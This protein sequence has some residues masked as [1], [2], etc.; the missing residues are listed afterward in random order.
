MSVSMLPA[1]AEVVQVGSGSYT[2]TYPGVDEKNRN[3]VPR[4]LPQVSGRAA[5]RPIPTNDWWSNV[6][7]ENQSGNL[8]AYP[9]AMRTKTDG[10]ALAYIPKGPMIDFD[11]VRV[12]V[13][14]ISSDKT[15]VSDFSDWTVTMRWGNDSEYFEGTA[16][17]AM[18]F[19]YFTK[20]S[21]Q[22][23]KIA[24]Y[25][26]FGTVTVKDEML[27]V[28]KGF[29]GASFAVYAP[30]GSEWTLTGGKTYESSLGGKDYWSVAML[31]LD[32]PDAVEAASQLKKY[33]YVFPKDTRALW[34]FDEKTSVVRTDYVVT[35]DVKEGAESQVLMGLL[36]HHWAHLSAD[37]AQPDGASYTTIRGEMKTLGGNKF[38]T[39]N[40]FH[41]ILP[42][43][44]YVEEGKNGFSTEELDALIASVTGDHGLVDWTD[45]YNDGQL[46]NRLI[47]TARVAK[48]AGNEAEFK[49]AFDLIKDRVENWLTYSDGE[50]AFLFYYHKDW[51]ALLGYPA[52][53]GQDEY[54]NDHHFHW[55]YFIHAAAFLEQ[56]EPGW[57]ERWGEMVDLLVR[58]AATT[59]RDD[60]MFPYIRN[61]SPFAGHCWANGV[62]V[63]PQGNDQESSSESMQFHSSLIHWGA[64]TGNKAVRDLGI[65]MYATEQSAIEE[66]WFDVNERILPADWP[67]SLV[68]RVFGNDFDNATFWTQNIAASYGIE[69]YPIHG[70]SFYLSRDLDYAR[71]LWTEITEKTGIL[72]NEVNPDLWHDVMWEY[73]AFT[74]PQK[75]IELYNSYRD[76]SLKFGISPAQTYHWIHAMA[77]LGQFDSSITADY[78]I[79]M[80]FDQ[81][82]TVS[83]VAHNYG[84]DALTV[85][86]S[87]GFKL[88][89]EP[90]KTAVGT[91]QSTLPSVRLTAPDNGV[92]VTIGNTVGLTAEAS[93]LKGEISYVEFY[94]GKTLIKRCEE[95]PYACDWTP[96]TVGRYTLTAKAVSS[97]GREK[98]SDPVVVNVA[99]ELSGDTYDC[100]VTSTELSEGSEQLQQG[101]VMQFETAGNGVRITCECLDSKVGLVGYLFDRTNGFREYQMSQ[102]SANS[103]T[104]TLPDLIY[105]TKIKFACK[106]AFAGGYVVTKDFEYEVGAPCKSSGVEN[107]LGDGA[108]K[109]YPNPVAATL[110]LDMPEGGNHVYVWSGDGRLMEEA[111]FPSQAAIDMQQWNPGVYFVRIENEAGCYVTKVVKK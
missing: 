4:G 46:L 107:V 20:N 19:V 102:V 65:Y 45:S 74:N 7:Y 99:N 57:A 49:K 73:L 52:G 10:L 90:G 13:G 77:C 41:G 23:V 83:Y 98:V 106:F 87:D 50:V 44:P 48:E 64:V 30:A 86:F 12:G 29:N 62:A 59:D 17:I 1:R 38:T 91:G 21:T 32:T 40:V 81:N 109:V 31:P 88:D 92:L 105:G 36:P 2:T 108:V 3:K 76:R 15:T 54:L 47:Q 93:V 94:N 67:H 111:D 100:N 95:Q 58:D 53:H 79:A 63:F 22:N 89:V 34:S 55:G 69:L 37:S 110:H 103:F 27:V 66:Y 71:R 84:K 96:E 72:H 26:A 97:E 85:T 75:A 9:I 25:E 18:P 101:Y 82:G 104:F 60:P 43:L 39:E 35:P 61:F 70:G 78:P 33:A 80:A 16:G 8:F 14:G 42:T 28:E 6:L 24:I 56:Y 51:T 11:P 5:E 68:S